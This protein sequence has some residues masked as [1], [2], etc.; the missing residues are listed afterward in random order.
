MVIIRVIG[1]N[2]FFPFLGMNW[3]I[4]APVES[5]GN[6]SSSA[7]GVCYERQRHEDEPVR[8]SSFNKSV[9]NLLILRGKELRDADT[10]PFKSTQM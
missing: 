8:R 3:E 2:L 4:K 10:M 9:A 7:L 1:R 5:S 6:A